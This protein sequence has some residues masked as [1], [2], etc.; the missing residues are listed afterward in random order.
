[1]RAGISAFGEHPYMIGKNGEPMVVARAKYVSDKTAGDRIL[2]LALRAADESMHSLRESLTGHGAVVLGLP[3]GEWS[4]PDDK[5]E[6]F[7]SGLNLH[8]R[9]ANLQS[10]QNF[11][12]GH[13]AGIM[14]LHWARGLL[15]AGDAEWCL[16]GA[17]DSYLQ[18]E[19][20]EA[21]DEDGELHS[22]GNAWGMVPGEGAGFCLL[23]TRRYAVSHRFEVFGEL[24]S[25]CTTYETNVSKS[26]AVCLGQGLTSAFRSVLAVV[27]EAEKVDSVICDMN[28]S[29][30]RAD[31]YG[32]VIARLG[33][34]FRDATEV[35]TPADCWGDVGAASG[36]LFL[37]L[38]VA[39]ARKGYARGPNTLLW[40]SSETGER[41]A[42]LVHTAEVERAR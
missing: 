11:A 27:P 5:Y 30:S 26:G 42:A 8:I 6:V 35:L 41:A 3:H 23:T 32:F 9:G 1:V 12:T 4:F 31:E 18:P 22:V 39:A 14:A 40:A 16:V 25:A 29:P 34:R 10:I 17:A 15:A 21:L 19:R 33:D 7:K 2:N 36:V 13:A 38:A 20:L 24:T 28:G 37:G